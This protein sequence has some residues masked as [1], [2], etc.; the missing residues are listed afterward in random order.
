MSEDAARAKLKEVFGYDD[1]RGNQAEV[2]A[3]VTAGGNAVV[4]MPT[5][6]GKSLCFQIPALLREGTGIVI[7][8]LIALMEDQVKALTAVGVRA[9]F[10]NS[11][12]SYAEQKVVEDAYV[13]GELDLLYLA[14]ERLAS[15]GTKRF[16]SRGR[17]A[18]FAIDEAHCVSQWGHDF[19]P[20]YL[21]LAD[22]PKHWTDVPRIALT[23]TAT[24]R[25][26]REISSVLKMEK[27]RH[28]ITSFDRPNISYRV[29]KKVAPRQQLLDF[30]QQEHANESGV[31]YAFTRST[32]ESTAESLVK[33]GI[34]AIPYHAGLP[35]ETRA[36]S[37]R[38]FL[39]NSGT[40]IVATIA[41]GMGID[42][43][44]VRFVAHIDLPKSVE[45]F[46]QES[47]RAGRDGLPS[48]ALLLYGVRDYDSQSQMIA[49][50]DLPDERRLKLQ[51]DLDAMLDLCITPS[52]R[53]VQLLAYFGQGSEPC[54][55]CD[56][57]AI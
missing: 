51:A 11:S 26:H 4:L 56:A 17:I 7:S 55:N 45:G 14:P 9:A 48:A 5:G 40:V 12:Q 10:L 38:E 36:E 34:R 13:A 57:C 46:Y 32:V 3:H 29:V 44:D 28:F 54:G 53:R 22:I 1:F 24:E 30:I 19:R 25:T 16:L 31:V 6:G 27:A 18:L 21:R 23:A 20:D 8:P 41:F 42:K 35:P 43:A 15:E 2:I 49:D 33:R 47:G 50:S 37:Q 52:C 39:T